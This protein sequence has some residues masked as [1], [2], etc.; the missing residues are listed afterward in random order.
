MAKHQT[1][2]K[3]SQGQRKGVRSDATTQEINKYL[4]T[5]QKLNSSYNRISLQDD[6][7]ETERLNLRRG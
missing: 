3:S 4:S 2:L 6:S 7:L 1:S 5:N